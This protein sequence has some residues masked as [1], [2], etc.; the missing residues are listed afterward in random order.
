MGILP[1]IKSIFFYLIRKNFNLVHHYHFYTQNRDFAYWYKYMPVYLLIEMLKYFYG[2]HI[3]YL[4]DNT[5][6]S[7]YLTIIGLDR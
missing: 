4:I 1:E 6:K 3:T 5:T 7:L 2:M